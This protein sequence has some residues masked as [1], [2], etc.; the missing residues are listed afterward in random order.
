MLES[1]LGIG[2][3]PRYSGFGR[4]GSSSLSGL[5][6]PVEAAACDD[7]VGVVEQPVQDADGG[8]VLGQDRLQDSKGQWLAIVGG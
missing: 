3:R 4:G 5:A 2:I 8:G 1:T 7:H 6:H